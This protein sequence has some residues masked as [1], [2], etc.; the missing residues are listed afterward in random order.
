SYTNSG[1]TLRFS[2]MFVGEIEKDFPIVLRHRMFA[3]ANEVAELAVDQLAGFWYL[4]RV[5]PACF[6]EAI[7]RIGS[8]QHF[9]LA[10]GIHPSVFGRSGEK[11]RACRTQNNE[12]ILIERQPVHLLVDLFELGVEPVR[13][14][15]VDL[16]DRLTDFA[17]AG[18]R[19]SAARL[20]RNRQR[21]AL[22]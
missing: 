22:I 1:S 15:S 16:L 12:T 10:R 17:T 5:K 13:K 8:L 3:G 18:T 14:A 4:P 19:A 7:D 2:K 9:E 21:K 20:Q 11:P 6:Q